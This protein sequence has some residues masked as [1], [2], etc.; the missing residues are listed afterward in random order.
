MRESAPIISDV[1][2]V[3]LLQFPYEIILKKSND[4]LIIEDIMAKDSFIAVNTDLTEEINKQKLAEKEF[5]SV[6]D[7]MKFLGLLLINKSN[8]PIYDIELIEPLKM[9]FESVRNSLE[10]FHRV[11]SNNGKKYLFTNQLRPAF[12][13]KMVFINFVVFEI[14]K[15]PEDNVFAGDNLKVLLELSMKVPDNMV[16][17]KNMN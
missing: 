10:V 7:I 17:F 6:M 12:D 2:K 1:E 15:M 5:N 8:M 14:I 16:L 13:E 11:M 4:K 3:L 9:L